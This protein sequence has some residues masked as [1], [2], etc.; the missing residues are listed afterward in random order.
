MTDH[1][2]GDGHDMFDGIKLYKFV[3]QQIVNVGVTAHYT[4]DP[5]NK[6]VLN[7]R[8]EIGVNNI[9]FIEYIP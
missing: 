9:E 5:C 8:L 7:V 4:L 2:N 3:K 1:E 6:L